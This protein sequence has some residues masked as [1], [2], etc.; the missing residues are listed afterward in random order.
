MGDSAADLA[1]QVQ[2]ILLN[3]SEATRIASNGLSE[4]LPDLQATVHETRGIA[5]DV[6]TETGLI[7]GKTK[8]ALTPESKI[9]M[10]LKGL[11]NGTLTA[12]SLWYYLSH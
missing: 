1:S 2:P 5:E 6:H 8:E 11:V 10:I 7:V 9:K 12:A 4:S 3:A